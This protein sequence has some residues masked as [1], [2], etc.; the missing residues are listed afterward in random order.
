MAITNLHVTNPTGGVAKTPVL[1]VTQYDLVSSFMMAV[2]I[3]LG[4]AV[5]CLAIMWITNRIDRLGGPERKP[6]FSIFN[7]GGFLDRT[8]DEKLGLV[9]YKPIKGLS[10]FDTPT[11]ET[12][13][14]EVIDTILVLAEN[15]AVQAP[16]QVED[17]SE[18]KGP[19]GS[20]TDNRELGNGDGKSGIPSD[21]RWFVR[22]S[23][24]GTLNEYARQLD[25]F[26]IE[27]GAE[28]PGGKLTYL[29]N[30]SADKS[31]KRDLNNR[32]DEKRLNMSWRGGNRRKADVQLFRKAGIDVTGARIR[33]FYPPKTEAKMA[34]RER[35][36]QNRPTS[37]ILRTYFLVRSANPGYKFVVTRQ[38]YKR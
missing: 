11:D 13:I 34:R 29:S 21:Q 32:S 22:F 12:K 35:E 23:E 30:V 20:G 25:F 33:H 38:S 19:V 5:V 2:V 3:G 18:T 17:D 1:K 16:P 36:Y 6:D 27:L 26:G 7:A 10:P 37:Q 15:A 4:V 9:F 8:P 28:F 31:V 14:E 24:R